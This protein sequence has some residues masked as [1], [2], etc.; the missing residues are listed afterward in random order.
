LNPLWQI[1]KLKDSKLKREWL[2]EM[3]KECFTP[4]KNS[5]ICAEL[6][7]EDSSE[8]VRG[9]LDLS[10]SLVDLHSRHTELSFKQQES[11]CPVAISQIK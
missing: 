7:T 3:A 2:I 8:P 9:F 10:F 6:F 1:N 5:C 4:S 11:T